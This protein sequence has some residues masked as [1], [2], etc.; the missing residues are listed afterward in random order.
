MND[1]EIKTDVDTEAPDVWPPLAHIFEGA[2]RVRKGDIALCGAK[3]MGIDLEGA[4][5]GKVC[6]K[7]AELA[8]KRLGQ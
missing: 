5:Q 8:A 1:T 4:T 6:A 3:L 7:C 2:R